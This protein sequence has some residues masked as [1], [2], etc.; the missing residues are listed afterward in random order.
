MYSCGVPAVCLASIL[1]ACPHLPA[2]LLSHLQMDEWGVGAVLTASQKALGTPP[3]LSILVLSQAAMKVRK[4]PCTL[5]YGTGC[6]D[7]SAQQGQQ[8]IH[9]C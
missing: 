3:G 6:S 5:Q 7:N 9:L 8:S 4:S 1:L 2:C